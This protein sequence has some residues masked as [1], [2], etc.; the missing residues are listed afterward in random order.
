VFFSDFPSPGRHVAYRLNMILI[1]GGT[2]TS[3]QPIVQGLLDRGERVRALSRDPEKA[4]RT[5][6]DDV[7]IARGNFSDP[8]SLEAAMEG[9]DR[10][11]LIVASLPDQPAMESAFIDAAGR[12]GVGYIVKFSVIRPDVNSPMRFMR[13]HAQ[14]EAKLKSSGIAWTMLRP[15]FFLQNLLG[16]AHSAKRGTIHMDAG[17]GQT[18][19]VDT[20]DIAAVAVTALT[21]RGH[22]GK[23]YEITGPRAV[24]MADVAREIS[25]VSGREVKYVNVPPEAAKQALMQ[26][27]VP[28]W[29]AAGINELNA[30]LREGKMANVT[31][32]V[33]EIGKKE[34]TT[35]QQFVRENA[36]VFR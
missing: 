12:A 16:L 15:T 10:A 6:G 14:A 23:T 3:G 1:T 9:V 36:N 29:N 28:E 34:P 8:A 26:A 11:M 27:G 22:E 25:A 33:R 35:L 24:G 21:E 31:D 17:D 13:G 20:R 2:G 4:A 18:P 32:V 19:F 5:L 7:E 30:A